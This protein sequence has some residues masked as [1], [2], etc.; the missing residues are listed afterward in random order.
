MVPPLTRAGCGRRARVL[1]PAATMGPGRRG[2]QPAA[3]SGATQRGT[4]RRCGHVLA[5]GTVTEE[6]PDDQG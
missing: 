6:G 1:S 4:F 3:P 5:A 2:L